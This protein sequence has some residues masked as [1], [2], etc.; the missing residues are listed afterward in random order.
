MCQAEVDGERSNSAPT[1]REIC[2]MWLLSNEMKQDEEQ[3]YA[4]GMLLPR[5][6]I[7]VKDKDLPF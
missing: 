3:L 6:P 2:D 5:P 4:S 7:E 1:E